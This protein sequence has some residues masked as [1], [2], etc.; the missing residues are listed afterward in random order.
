MQTEVRRN[1]EEMEELQ[2]IIS[3]L[4]SELEEKDVALIARENESKDYKQRLQKGKEQVGY[5]RLFV[6]L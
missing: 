5:F 6:T 4:K 3:N 1:F 2:G